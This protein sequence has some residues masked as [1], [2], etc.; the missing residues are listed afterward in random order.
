MSIGAPAED[1][2]YFI[3]FEHLFTAVND[4]VLDR[5]PPQ[6]NAQG[7]RWGGYAGLCVRFDQ[8][9]SNP[10]YFSAQSDSMNS[11][12]RAS[13]VA[14]N[15]KAPDGKTVQI[16][17]VDHTEN[18]RYP[19]PW[20]VINRPNDR[21]WYY[22][23]AILYHEPLKLKAGEKMTLRYR[24]IVPAE[25]LTREEILKAEGR[26]QKGRKESTRNK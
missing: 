18:V 9:L 25:P 3:D 23:A 13:W 1:G 15:L 11:G 6:T 14:A 17:L 7:I 12:E 4:V 26:G 10:S 20:Y 2:S 19:T 5:T 16:V 22:N 8:N 24:V 21:F